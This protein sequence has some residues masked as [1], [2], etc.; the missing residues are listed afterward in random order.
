MK[1]NMVEGMNYLL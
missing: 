1:N